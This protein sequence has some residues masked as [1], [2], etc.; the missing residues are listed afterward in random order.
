V[1][2]PEL[3]QVLLAAGAAQV[4][5]VLV[6]VAAVALLVAHDQ[7]ALQYDQIRGHETIKAAQLQRN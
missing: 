6:E 3:L 7:A 5:H 1:P 2:C 4:D